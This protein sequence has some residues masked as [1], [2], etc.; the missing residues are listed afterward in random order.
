MRTKWLIIVLAF[1]L[2][3]S[4]A[5]A[6]PVFTIEAKLAGGKKT[7]SYVCAVSVLQ[8]PGGA[9]AMEHEFTLKAGTSAVYR[10]G[11]NPTAGEGYDR[12]LTCSI[13][14]DAK[15]ATVDFVNADTQ[16]GKPASL[17]THTQVFK[18]D[19]PH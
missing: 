18:I 4:S 13:S 15:Q 14:Q 3:F 5:I 9:I 12:K 7:G 2:S 16:D 8:H 1:A 17:S 6:S 10:K 19:P 11:S